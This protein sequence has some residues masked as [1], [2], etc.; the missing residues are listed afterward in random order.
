MESKRN[1]FVEE[2]YGLVYL[3]VKRFKNRG[4]EP[5]ELFQIGVIGLLKA[6]DRY[7]K[8][9]GFSFS[10]YAVPLITGEI[11]R[12]LRDD[13]MIHI[14]R[15]VK[16]NARKIS[17]VREQ[18]KKSCNRE[19]TL[20]EIQNASGLSKEEIL[21]AMNANVSLV[22][23]DNE[24][25]HLEICAPASFEQETHCL[26]RM[27]V[28]EMLQ[29]LKGEE[30]QLIW[31]RYFEGKTQGEVAKALGKNQVAISRL[32]KKILL[33]LRNKFYYNKQSG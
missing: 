25:E 5:S 2:N 1:Q 10:T 18:L 30:R 28:Q 24:L 8:S 6:A 16:D 15:S 3:V 33:Q 9:T 11:Q 19:A 13:G 20:E 27:L 29:S 22:S 14:S 7:D 32:E 23:T 21:C 17:I 26:D 31:L 4:Y 12:F